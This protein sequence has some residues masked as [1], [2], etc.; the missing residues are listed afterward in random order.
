MTFNHA[1]GVQLPVGAEEFFMNKDE[2]RLSIILPVF[3]GGKTLKRTLDSIVIQQ[4]DYKY[5][6]V[7]INDSS[8]DESVEIIEA[9]SKILPI[10]LVNVNLEV[11]CAGN[12]R[13]LALGKCKGEWVTFIDQDDEFEPD[14]F[15]Q[16]FETID[17]NKLKYICCTMLYEFD[18]DTGRIVEHTNFQDNI[19]VWLHGKYYNRKNLLEVYSEDIHFKKD[20]KYLED[21]YFNNRVIYVLFKLGLL[22][23]PTFVYYPINT[24]KWYD[25]GSSTHSKLVNG[26]YIFNHWGIAN[27]YCDVVFP[28]ILKMR[29]YIRNLESEASMIQMVYADLGYLYVNYNILV[30]NYGEYDKQTIKL[31]NKICKY[32]PKLLKYFR[33]TNVFDYTY[34]TI[35]YTLKTYNLSQDELNR[36]I[37]IAFPAWW[38]MILTRSSKH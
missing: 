24:Y 4:F 32:L 3:N 31:L 34:P 16:V 23:R 15:K 20:L 5:E 22:N 38:N 19:D 7:I 13:Q 11:H 36:L 29:K 12:S 30:A 10:N 18:E 8:T 2:L 14:A 33:I 37:H 25:H 28:P 35:E 26:G 27:H 17:F 21:L 6:V 9:Y 1:T